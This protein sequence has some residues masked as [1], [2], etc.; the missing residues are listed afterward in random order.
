LTRSQLWGLLD[1]F[2][3]VESVLLSAYENEEREIWRK[4]F[5]DKKGH[6]SFTFS[7]FPGDDPG[8]CG[9][10]QVYNLLRPIEEKPL[11]PKTRMLFDEGTAI[12]HM[13]VK[14]W[15][16]Y[17]V[18]LSAD[19]TGDDDFQTYFED[20][21]CWATG[22]PDA[23]LLPPF[24]TKSHVVEVKTTEQGKIERMKNEPDFFIYSHRKYVRQLQV[25]IAEA[26]DKFSHT[27]ITCEKSGVLIKNGQE[28]CAAVHPGKC[29][30]KVL[31]VEPPDDGTLLYASREEPLTCMMS[32][33]V[34]HDPSVIIEGKKRLKSWKEDFING[35]LP[36]HVDG[37]NSKKWTSGECRYCD[38]KSIAC[39]VDFKN[40][41]KNLKDS[42]LIKYNKKMKPDYDY[43]K[44]R[45]EVLDRW[46]NV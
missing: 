9:R 16:N 5:G 31:K 3:P 17:G 6:T 41:T 1:N 12:E 14:R 34:P 20:P 45:S 7:K 35:I 39:K 29:I 46:S 8:V 43:D 37:T 44:V 23:I 10:A 15:S 22:N 27:V 4:G 11:T 38:M 40:K 32:Y 2:T 21:E 18:L 19:I 28:K 33:Y 36:D 30:P 13:F 26:H 42:E 24:Y 25:N